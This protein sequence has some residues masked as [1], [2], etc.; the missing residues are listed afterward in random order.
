MPLVAQVF[1]SFVEDKWNW[2]ALIDGVF[3]VKS[4]YELLISNIELFTLDNQWKSR[5]PPK[6]VAFAWCVVLNRLPTRADLFRRQVIV[7]ISDTGCVLY[8]GT[9]EIHLF[10][11]CEFLVRLWYLVFRW[12]L[13]PDLPSLFFILFV[14]VNPTKGR[15][16]LIMIWHAAL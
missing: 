13:S 16:G 5:V 7:D 6:V 11:R 9:L 1:L 8:V 14:G 2:E 3:Y 15:K 12:L 10:L 4:T